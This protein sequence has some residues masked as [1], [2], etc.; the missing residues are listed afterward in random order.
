MDNALN[1]FEVLSVYYVSRDGLINSF[2]LSD[3]SESPYP[4]VVQFVILDSRPK[5]RFSSPS[6]NT[7]LNMVISLSI[8]TFYR[9]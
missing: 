8:T 9:G 3:M 5:L 1:I 6:S 2:I 4:D 7:Y